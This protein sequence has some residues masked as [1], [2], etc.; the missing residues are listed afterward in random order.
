MKNYKI[1]LLRHGRTS[2][3][4]QAKFVGRTDLSLSDSGCAELKEMCEKYE[5][6]GAQ[7]V[8]SSPLMR[9][10]QTAEILYPS[11]EL[12]TVDDLAEYDFGPY[13]NK[14][15]DELTKDASF[16]AWL[17][18]GIPA[19]GMEDTR[20][21]E[22]RITRG[23]EFVLKDM[24]NRGISESVL[25]AHGGVI[26]TLLAAHGLP[27]REPHLWMTGNGCGFTV[28][29]SAMLWAQ[30]QVMEVFDPLPYGIVDREPS[31]V[32]NVIDLN[33]END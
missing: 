12:C 7:R 25:I 26:M 17:K 24:M 32:Y 5:Y 27:K 30:G 31:K 28:T 3:N 18:S 22:Q 14:G 15:A 2:A 13:E 8:Y 4:E 16:M 1:H 10:T 11:L 21:F 19:E 9:C 6:P 23:F 33:D 29:T 20:L